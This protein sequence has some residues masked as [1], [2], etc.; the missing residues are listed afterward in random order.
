MA[1]FH[2]GRD[3]LRRARIDEAVHTD[4]RLMN[5]LMA[6][7]LRGHAERITE[8]KSSQSADRPIRFERLRLLH[9]VRHELLP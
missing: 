4:V 1:S 9:E 6:H 7:R 8:S 5:L 2:G 3:G